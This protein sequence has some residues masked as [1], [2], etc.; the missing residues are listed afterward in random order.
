ML[1]S[2]AAVCWPY[3]GTIPAAF[4]SDGMPQSPS[5]GQEDEDSEALGMQGRK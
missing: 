2:F 1:S 3:T 4:S 5:E